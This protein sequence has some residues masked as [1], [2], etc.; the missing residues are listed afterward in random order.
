MARYKHTRCT[1][2]CVCV[3]FDSKKKNVLQFS[4][5]LSLLLCLLWIEMSIAIQSYHIIQNNIHFRIVKISR[6]F[7]FI[8]SFI[9]TSQAYN[10]VSFLLIVVSVF[11]IYLWFIDMI[12]IIA[13]GLKFISRMM[14]FYAIHNNHN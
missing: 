14:N 13:F 12:E 2:M 11:H 7:S 4:S 9:H 8:S 10:S 3:W 1:C 6:S 5:H